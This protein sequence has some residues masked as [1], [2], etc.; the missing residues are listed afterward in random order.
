VTLFVLLALGLL[1]VIDGLNTLMGPS[2]G[3]IDRL[4]ATWNAN[5]DYWLRTIAPQQQQP[6]PA[7]PR[8]TLQ[9][10]VADQQL[11]A[12]YDLWLPTSDPLYVAIEQG[13]RRAR[14]ARLVADL[15]GTVQVGEFPLGFRKR[16]TNDLGF[17][18]PRTDRPGPGLGHVHLESEPYNVT[19][20]DIDV[21]VEPPSA[22]FPAKV[23][24]IVVVRT[25]QP[26]FVDAPAA[27]YRPADIVV[28]RNTDALSTVRWRDGHDDNV[29]TMLRRIGNFTVP[30]FGGSLNRLVAVYL[31][32]LVVFWLRR[33]R[34][35]DARFARLERPARFGLVLAV[36]NA[37][38]A[39]TVDF[40]GRFGSI[41][42]RFTYSPLLPSFNSGEAEILAVLVAVVV[43]PAAVTGVVSTGPARRPRLATGSAFVLYGLTV[44]ATLALFAHEY[45]VVPEATPLAAGLWVVTSVL[46]LLGLR[47]L[48]GAL[49][50]RFRWALAAVAAA[51]VNLA[52]AAQQTVDVVLQDRINYVRVAVF[53]SAIVLSVLTAAVFAARSVKAVGGS[54][55]P[56]NRRGLAAAAAGLVVVPA[57]GFL[58]QLL[59]LGPDQP[60]VGPGDLVG[61]LDWLTSLVTFVF[62]PILILLALR[63][64]ARDG[65]VRAPA[66]A[67][68][69]AAAVYLVVVVEADTRW[70]YLPVTAGAAVLVAL[71]LVRRRFE[72]EPPPDLQLRLIDRISWLLLENDALRRRR[73]AL[74]ADLELV[75]YAELPEVIKARRQ[76]DAQLS[77]VSI[78]APRHR[79]LLADRW[80]QA[81]WGAVAGSLLGAPLTVI[82]LS[83][84]RAES[85]HDGGFADP[86][87]VVTIVWN[88]TMWTVV[89]L[90][91]G[92][93]YPWIR[94]RSGVAKGLALAL[95]VFAP[96]LVNDFI[97]YEPGDWRSVAVYGLQ[98]FVVA[99]PLGV[100][101]GDLPLLEPLGLGWRYLGDLYNAR[102]AALWTSSLVLALGG[103]V[104]TA[105]TAGLSELAKAVLG[106]LATVPPTPGGG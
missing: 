21:H 70:A 106:H 50:P 73:R 16:Q 62:L 45:T 65:V 4:N 44:A 10:K 95:V 66:F 57:V 63:V 23:D 99:L 96:T 67:A 32:L 81:V 15:L 14:T 7:A 58:L 90:F 36:A 75:P 27:S 60:D 78:R 83:Q 102:F 104:G 100:V 101:V 72:I 22:G 19:L 74:I 88:L 8:R 46:L 28:D 13:H 9:L 93:F 12:V 34:P 84:F 35:F 82:Y 85:V 61:T 31:P 97:N 91:F 41:T 24:Q 103:I 89:G 55:R 18:A 71:A 25:G 92:F 68:P 56:W 5:N 39:L 6:A 42:S 26:V 76:L 79:E 86:S 69:W 38:L 20:P 2:S 87:Y 64:A 77:A 47:V 105:A 40:E 43:L 53:G 51:V 1:V 11:T 49:V 37:A 17:Q 94:G 48:A 54:L 30:G 33:L 98:V 3:S 59:P 29:V 52:V 80:R